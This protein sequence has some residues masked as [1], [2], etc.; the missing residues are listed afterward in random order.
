MS[1]MHWNGDDRER[2]ARRIRY[3]FL[4]PDGSESRE[5][6]EIIAYKGYGGSHIRNSHLLVTPWL[7]F[8]TRVCMRG[9]CQFK[10]PAGCLT[11]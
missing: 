8:R 4:A 11:K 10:A 5:A 6:A 3:D 7:L 2:M 1:N 9:Y